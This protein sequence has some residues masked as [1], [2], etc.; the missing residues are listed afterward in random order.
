[1]TPR[2]TQLR[3]SAADRH[4]AIAA[5]GTV[6]AGVRVALRAP[7]LAAHA[8][9]DASDGPRAAVQVLLTATERAAALAFARAAGT[10]G[11]CAGARVAL[12]ALTA[13]REAP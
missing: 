12:R 1:M 5:A 9:G 13:T 6:A 8:P 10:A 4:R 7:H 2:R 11:I 3:L